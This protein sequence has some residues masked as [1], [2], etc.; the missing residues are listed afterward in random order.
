[1]PSQ[2]GGSLAAVLIGNTLYFCGGINPASSTI[3]GCG[4]YNLNTQLFS[5][6]PSLPVGVN[7]AAFATDGVDKFFVIGGR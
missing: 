5:T 3:S 1:M 7:H 6:M 4:K 2:Y